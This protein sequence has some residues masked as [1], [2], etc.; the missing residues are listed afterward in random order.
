[1]EGLFKDERPA[2]ITP[3]TLEHVFSSFPGL[4]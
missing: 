1:M 2:P 3:E 4:R